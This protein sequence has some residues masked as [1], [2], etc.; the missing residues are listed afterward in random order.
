MTP[1]VHVGTWAGSL[2]FFGEA[3]SVAVYKWRGRSA[4]TFQTYSVY[5]RDSNAWIRVV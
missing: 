2:A 1:E 3:F 4:L 5:L